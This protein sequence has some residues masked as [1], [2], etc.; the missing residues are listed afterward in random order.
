MEIFKRGSFPGESA[1]WLGAKLH[2]VA[3]LC[4]PQKWELG[5]YNEITCINS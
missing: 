3:D 4:M 1:R 5:K 2:V